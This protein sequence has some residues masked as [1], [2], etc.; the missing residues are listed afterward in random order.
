MT[1]VELKVVLTGPMAAALPARLAELGFTMGECHQETDLYFNGGGRD[2]R[3]TDEALRLR[4]ALSAG[5]DG[6]TFVTYKGPKRDPRSNTRLEYETVVGNFDTARDILC[7]LGFQPVF[8]VEKVRQTFLRGPVTACLD[9]VNGLGDFLEL[10]HL[11][12]DG[13][14][15]D[16]AVDELLA[17][18]D[19]LGIARQALERRS[20]L[21]LLLSAQGVPSSKKRGD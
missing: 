20:Y 18:L 6:T 21:E 11:L 10:E 15:R 4:R 17:L 7:A 16:P 19:G 1:E 13:A 3:K 9:Q 5:G 14:A 12:P 8:T 2:F